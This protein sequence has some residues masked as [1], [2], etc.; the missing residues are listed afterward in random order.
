MVQARGKEGD[1]TSIARVRVKGD[2]GVRVADGRV[3]VRSRARIRARV[4]A[5]AGAGRNIMPLGSITFRALKESLLQAASKVCGDEGRDGERTANRR[6]YM[7]EAF[8][9]I[10]EVGRRAGG[11]VMTGSWVRCIQG[12]QATQ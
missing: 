5:R 8:N 11:P 3:R 12:E 7:E 1:Y 6:A 9:S 4:R 2:R 10:G